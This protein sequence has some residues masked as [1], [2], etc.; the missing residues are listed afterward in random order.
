MDRNGDGDIS[1]TEFLGTRDEFD[2]IDTDRDGLIS[3]GEAEAWDA[4]RRE[5]AAPK[6]TE[7]PKAG[8]EPMKENR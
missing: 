6:P 3:L 1:R 8:P 7:K 5:K 2:A 4:A